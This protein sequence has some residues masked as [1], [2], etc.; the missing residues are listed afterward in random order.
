M[1]NRSTKLFAIIAMI[2]SALS[3]GCF[4]ISYTL[5]IPARWLAALSLACYLLEARF[6]GNKAYMGIDP[7]FNYILFAVLLGGLPMFVLFG[8]SNRVTHFYIW[9]AYAVI[10][11]IVEVI[12]FP[13]RIWE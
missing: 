2:I 7:I 8:L 1:R 3:L 10:M 5:W 9:N 4:F 11:L 13:R 12:S 6:C